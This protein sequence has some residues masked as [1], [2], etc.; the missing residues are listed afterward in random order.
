MISQPS[1]HPR[2]AGKTK[3]KRCGSVALKIHTWLEHIKGVDVHL[4]L[5]SV[6]KSDIATRSA[7]SVL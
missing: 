4:P 5:K 2:T 3:K 7:K 6:R 1:T